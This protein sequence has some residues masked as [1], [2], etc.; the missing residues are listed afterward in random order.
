MDCRRLH[1]LIDSRAG[2]LINKLRFCCVAARGSSAMRRRR[3]VN[4]R[5]DARPLSLPPHLVEQVEEALDADVAG[6]LP[7]LLRLTDLRR[8]FPV[9]KSWRWSGWRRWMGRR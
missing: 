3:S 7:E 2:G 9:W 5:W 8:A 1:S 4:A 6:A